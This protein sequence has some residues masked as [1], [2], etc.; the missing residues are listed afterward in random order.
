MAIFELAVVFVSSFSDE[1]V[2]RQSSS[3]R[4]KPL[5]TAN[6]AHVY[7]AS[8]K[9]SYDNARI[10]SVFVAEQKDGSSSRIMIRLLIIGSSGL[11]D[12]C[13]V[14]WYVPVSYTHLTLPTILLV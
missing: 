11:K 1:S 9:M 7:A 13:F 3:D 12:R 4:F 8:S 2:T 5:L 10:G 14:L 6:P